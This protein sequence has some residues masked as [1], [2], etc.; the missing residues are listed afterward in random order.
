MTPK[1]SLEKLRIE[2]IK[3]GF[4]FNT[5][6]SLQDAQY[7]NRILEWILTW[8]YKQLS[9]ALKSFAQEKLVTC[10]ARMPKKRELENCDSRINHHT[11]CAKCSE[12]AVAQIVLESCVEVIEHEI[13]KLK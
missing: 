10:L 9:S 6:R 13:D 11:Y 12:T 2:F 4:A 1:E 7:V 8:H 5:N 3:A